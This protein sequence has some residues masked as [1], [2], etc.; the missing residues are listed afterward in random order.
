[1]FERYHQAKLAC[2]VGVMALR[3]K[4]SERGSKVKVLG[5][6]SNFNQFM[7]IKGFA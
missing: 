5:A 4:L 3:T 2:V 6:A 1:M 7:E